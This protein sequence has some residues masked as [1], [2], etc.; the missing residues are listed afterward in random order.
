MTIVAKLFIQFIFIP[1]EY[2]TRSNCY[3]SSQ[4]T[5]EATKTFRFSCPT[6]GNASSGHTIF[7]AEL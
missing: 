1:K 2:E 4:T 3:S 6:D 5:E 7:D